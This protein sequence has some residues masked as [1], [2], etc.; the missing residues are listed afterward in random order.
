MIVLEGFS[1]TEY[2]DTKDKRTIGVGLTG[3]YFPKP[4]ETL[5]DAFMRAYADKE[6]KARDLFPEY[7]DFSPELQTQIMSGVY[8]GDF[9]EG[10]N[11]VDAIKRGDFTE[12]GRQFLLNSDR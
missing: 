12:A 5:H 11:T 3:E 9:K 10:Y 4:D 1:K 6:T 8:R 7:N 2:L